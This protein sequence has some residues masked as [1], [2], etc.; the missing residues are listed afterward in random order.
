MEADGAPRKAIRAALHHRDF[1]LLV[2]AQT[3]SGTGDWLYTVALIAYVLDRTHSPA[4]VGLAGAIRFAPYVVFSTF[5]GLVAD[6]YDR[7]KVM[8]VMDLA[9]GV[10]M[11]GLTIVAAANGAA[12]TAIVL[13]AGCTTFSAF[14]LPCAGASTPALVGEEDLAAANA[15]ISTVSSLALAIGPAVGG[16]LL[17][18]GSSTTAFAVNAATFFVSAAFTVPIRTK[19]SRAV[20]PGQEDEPTQLRHRLGEG[21]KAMSSSPTV[22]V[23][24]V[25][26]IGF[27]LFYGLEIVLYPLASSQLLGLGAHGIG[28]M[29]AAI[30]VGG[31]LSAGAIGR[32]SR[33]GKQGGLLTLAAIVSG[34]PTCSPS[35]ERRRLPT[36]CSASKASRSSWARCSPSRCCSGSWTPICWDV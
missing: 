14:Y 33:S 2:I 17:L 7:R 11:V 27:M 8:I 15:I 13:A 36:W 23:V 35:C 34:L 32:V 22:L 18:L 28:F 31:I 24:A 5:G 29:F 21:L 12:I 3:I 26:S 30:G 16:L 20:R 9:Q 1:R 4:W 19:L 6:R 10:V 25:V